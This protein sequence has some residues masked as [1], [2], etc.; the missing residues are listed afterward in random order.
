MISLTQQI[1]TDH[2]L[3]MLGTVPGPGKTAVNKKIPALVE[4]RF[5]ETHEVGWGN[6]ARGTWEADTQ[7]S[8][9]VS[10]TRVRP[11]P[12]AG[13][14]VDFGPGGRGRLHLW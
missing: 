9:Q 14:R 12:G 8:S 1:F 11:C 6:L 7:V 2:L 13:R 10:K 3:C 4:L 5:Y